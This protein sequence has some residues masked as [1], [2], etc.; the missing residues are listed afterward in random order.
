MRK[1]L[2]LSA[3]ALLTTF[4]ARVRLIGPWAKERPTHFAF[5]LW[6]TEGP[7]HAQISDA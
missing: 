7:S 1:S 5:M 4:G 2:K 3:L 6:G